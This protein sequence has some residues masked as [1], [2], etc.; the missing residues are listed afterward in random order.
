M[1]ARVRERACVS[2]TTPSIIMRLA[3]T[4]LR[5]FAYSQLIY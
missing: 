4:A 2:V 1:S 3:W 5:K